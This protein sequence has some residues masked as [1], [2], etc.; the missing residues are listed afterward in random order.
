M[1]KWQYVEAPTFK[2]L[3]KLISYLCV[4]I[5]IKILSVLYFH[6]TGQNCIS[7]EF[8]CE[9][10][11]SGLENSFELNYGPQTVGHILS[12]KA[13]SRAICAHF[14]LEAALILS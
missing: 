11:G 9:N 3:C 5:F 4:T 12:G 6:F 2:Y 7:Y 10:W 1:N 14:L 8:F 13:M